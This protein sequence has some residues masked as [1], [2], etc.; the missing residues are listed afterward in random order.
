MVGVENGVAAKISIMY[1]GIN[2][3][4][5]SHIMAK[6]QWHGASMKA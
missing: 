6:Y 3:S 2:G 1:H 4:V 5:G